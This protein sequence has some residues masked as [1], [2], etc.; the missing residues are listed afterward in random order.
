LALERAAHRMRLR[1]VRMAEGKGEGYVGQGLQTADVLAV[2]FGAELRLARPGAGGA[3]GAPGAGGADRFL[4]STGHYSIGLWAAFAEAGLLAEADLDHYGRDGHPVAMSTIDGAL[5]GVELTGGSLGHGPGVAAGLALG[6]RMSGS[7]G[8]VFVYLSDGELQEGSVWEAAMFAGARDL[9]NL[10]AV[11]DINRT[12][13][14]GPLVLEV[15]P[16]A[17][18][19]RAFGW[20]C[21]EADGHDIAG[22]LAALDELRGMA[23]P[24]ALVCYTEIGHGVRLIAERERAHFVRVGDDEWEQVRL[25]LEGTAP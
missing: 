5:P 7:D 16:C 4:L 6:L 14:D 20:S 2:L 24:K 17:A 21:V 23:G 11:V 9:S 18:K 22:L 8:R 13:A 15:E 19:L 12:Q 10:W 1:A 25:E 3:D